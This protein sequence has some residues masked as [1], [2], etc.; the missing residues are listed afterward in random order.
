[1]L[2]DLRFPAIRPALKGPDPGYCPGFFGFTSHFSVLCNVSTAFYTFGGD[3]ALKI[4][5]I[6]FY[7]CELSNE[8][9]RIFNR[10]LT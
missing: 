2:M 4:G 1:M 7:K 5:I 8:D 9:C 3:N 10:Y 6:N